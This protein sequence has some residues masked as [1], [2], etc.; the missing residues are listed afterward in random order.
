MNIE[1][2]SILTAIIGAFFGALLRPIVEST[3]QSRL[4]NLFIEIE[5]RNIEVN[6]KGDLEN[7]IENSPELDKRMV[8]F[9]IKNNT[10]KTIRDF[11]LFIFGISDSIIFSYDS[12]KLD[13]TADIYSSHIAEVLDPTEE[14][15][16]RILIKYLKPRE[17]FYI[18]GHC[19]K[20]QDFIFTA[21]A[22][23]ELKWK[24]VSKNRPNFRTII[25]LLAIACGSAIVFGGVLSLFVAVRTLI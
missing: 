4:K 21:D 14:H 19:S 1:L 16:G 15:I 8:R 10:G 18:F 2:N 9:N 25:W 22:D 24:T 11:N 6:F 17:S 12:E 3:I 23:I 13:L 7:S 5:K 20:N